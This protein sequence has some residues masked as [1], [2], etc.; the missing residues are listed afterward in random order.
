MADFSAIEM[1]TGDRKLGG[2]RVGSEVR[3][4]K[5]CVSTWK[6]YR[7][8]WVVGVFLTAITMMTSSVLIWNQRKLESENLSLREDVSVLESKLQT[9]AVE[10]DLMKT[11]E[12]IHGSRRSDSGHRSAIH[13]RMKRSNG[14]RNGEN[15]QR[16]AKDSPRAVHFRLDAEENTTTELKWKIWAVPETRTART[17]RNEPRYLLNG[18]VRLSEDKTNVT[19]G[20]TGLYFIYAQ[21]QFENARPRNAFAVKVDGSYVMKCFQSLDYFNKSLTA[22]ENSRFKPCYSASSV[23]L[24]PNQVVSIVNLYP[25]RIF[26]D[27]AANFW[28]LIKLAD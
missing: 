16:K 7:L 21:I 9:V 26:N 1:A 3:S 4:V 11:K 24:H 17:R 14:N 22:Q 6:C 23:I 25:H 19:I 2:V 27:P 15:K 12:E 10:M 18:S 5:D 20:E 28:G 13:R 8:L